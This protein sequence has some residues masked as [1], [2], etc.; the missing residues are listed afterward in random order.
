MTRFF[1]LL[2]VPA[3]RARNGSVAGRGFLKSGFTSLEDPN[4]LKLRSLDSS[5]PFVLSDHSIW[6]SCAPNAMI[7]R[8]K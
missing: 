4:L 8:L 6:G 1:T 7:A 5:C 3:Q 2:G